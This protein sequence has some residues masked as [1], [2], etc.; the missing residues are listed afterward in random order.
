MKI[1]ICDDDK[2]F[3]EKVEDQLINY[4]TMRQIPVE[5]SVFTTADEFVHSELEIYN[6]VF[7]D[8]RIGKSNGIDAAQQ[9]RKRNSRAVLIFISA[10]VEYAIMGY[11]VHASAY[12]LKS[13]LDG[14][15][16]NCM[17]EVFQKTS[18]EPVSIIVP[19]EG[20]NVSIQSEHILY[21]ES[22]R[23]QLKLHTTLSALSTVQ[24][25]FKLSD[26]ESV[27][28][29]HG[30]LRIYKS[31]LINMDHC[32]AIQKKLALMDDGTEL[33]CSRQNYHQILEAFLRWK[34]ERVNEPFI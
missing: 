15:F 30:F 32:K 4:T 23:H 8:V 6:V 27:L 22:Y 11:S 14:T 29:Q 33:T 3:A 18:I 25:Y 26:L 21:I 9:L 31:Y 12:L 20:T 16:Q 13:D 1:A 19:Y 34:G 24:Y 7:L 28:C 2:E 10:F 5:V 17:D